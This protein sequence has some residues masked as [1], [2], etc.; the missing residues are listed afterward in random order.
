MG[1]TASAKQGRGLQNAP[2]RALPGRALGLLCWE[3]REA[4]FSWP[5]QQAKL[6]LQSQV[7]YF[8]VAGIGPLSI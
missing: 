6:V 5:T 8:T 7:L 1:L 2:A 4:H 3:V